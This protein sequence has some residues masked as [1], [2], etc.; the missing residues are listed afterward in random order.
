MASL[1]IM[2]LSNNKN[3]VLWFTG[4]PGS[5]K[6]TLAHNLCVAL[7]KRNL[8]AEH[9]DGDV[10]RKYISKDLSFTKNDRKENL[11]RTI[12]IAE[13]LAKNGIIVLVSLVSPYRAHRNIA[14]KFFVKRGIKFIE[15][16]CN[17]PL[18]VCMKREKH[19]L[20]RKAM[21]GKIKQFTGISAPYEFPLKPEIELQTYKNSAA[22]C[23]QKMLKYLKY[24]H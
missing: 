16:L 15:I 9:L 14:R 7:K 6:T 20:Y 12:F 22:E 24:Y 11:L 3:L 4:L 10:L 2:S 5:G 21:K 19:K 17:A 18:E 23:F 13:L 8:K 1:G